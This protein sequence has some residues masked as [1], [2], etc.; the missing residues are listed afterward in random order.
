MSIPGRTLLILVKH[1]IN[2][3][4]TSKDYWKYC[5]VILHCV[6]P[7]TN[8]LGGNR[9][10]GYNILYPASPSRIIVSLKTPGSATLPC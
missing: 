4:G 10:V 6:T 2:E 8:Q 5:H 3:E 1:A 9:L 7:H